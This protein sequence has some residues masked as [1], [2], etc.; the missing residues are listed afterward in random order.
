MSCN[1]RNYLPLYKSYCFMWVH[2]I[3]LINELILLAIDNMTNNFSCYRVKDPADK[4]NRGGNYVSL[5]F[6]RRRKNNT[7]YRWPV[8]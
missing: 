3:F 6:S 8:E 2:K 4:C 1:M 7:C 5:A